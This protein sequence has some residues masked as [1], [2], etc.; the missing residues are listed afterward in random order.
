MSV[1]IIGA[2]LIGQELAKK[3]SLKI[4]VDIIDPYRIIDIQGVGFFNCS[5][6]EFLNI[7]ENLN[8]YT[9][10]LNFSYPVKR[11]LSNDI[12]PDEETFEDSVKS[13]IGFYYK[14]MINSL[15]LLKNKQGSVL[16]AASIYSEF[17][18]RNDIYVGSKRST[19][20]DYISA[21]SSIIYMSKYF[22]KNFSKDIYFNTIS[23]GGVFNNHSS[24]FSKNYGKYSK[25]N[26]MLDIEKLAD[27]I[28]NIYDGKSIQM[29]GSNLIIDDGFTL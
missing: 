17:M 2:G 16:S 11:D 20:V 27:F 15:K 4:N 14:V 25:S 28:S 29:N 24:E 9:S 19:P 12:F 26:K 22:A 21:K 5:F 18:P 13:H 10:I 23:F 1:L 6:D 3:L 7:E 8:K